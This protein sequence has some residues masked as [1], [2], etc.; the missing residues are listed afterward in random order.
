MMFKGSKWKKLVKSNT[1]LRAMMM[2]MMQMVTMM[3]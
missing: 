3:L 1:E 2:A